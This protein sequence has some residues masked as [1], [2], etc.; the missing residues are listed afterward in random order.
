MSKPRVQ[1]TPRIDAVAVSRYAGRGPFLLWGRLAYID[2]TAG[3]GTCMLSVDGGPGGMLQMTRLKNGSGKGQPFFLCPV[4]GGRT[5]HIYVTERF[6]CRKCAGLCYQSQ[7]TRERG[8][9]IPWM[10]RSQQE[11]FR[12]DDPLF[13]VAGRGYLQTL[14]EVEAHWAG[15]RRVSLDLPDE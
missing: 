9:R 15:I 1:D 10:S 11:R 12:E 13:F 4:C 5:R 7:L 14:R 2:H 6:S 3:D 8:R